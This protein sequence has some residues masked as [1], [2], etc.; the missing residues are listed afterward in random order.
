[1]KKLRVLLLEDSPLDA[2]LTLATLAEAG[3]ECDVTRVDTR[4]TFTAA[5]DADA[6]TADA[7]AA[8]FGAASAAPLDLILADHQLPSFDGITALRIAR[9]R[10]PSVPFIFLSGTLGEELAIEAMKTGATDY[11]VK[12]RMTRLAPAVRRA[13]REAAE[14][15]RLE[16]TSAQLRGS[17]ERCRLV[18][19]TA[20]DFAIVTL[21]AAGVV[22]SWNGGAERILGFAPAE[23]VGR[24]FA[25]F[26]TPEDRAAGMPQE[27]L[28]R[29][30][31]EGRAD[32]DRWHVRKDGTRFFA[33]G[34]VTA[35][36]DGRF[37][38]F[39][40]ILRDTTGRKRE[41]ESLKRSIDRLRLLSETATYLL[42]THDQRQIV[43]DLFDKLSPQLSLEL[44]LAYLVEDVEAA[45]AHDLRLLA[46][47]GVADDALAGIRR[48]AVGQAVCGAV[49][50]DGRRL[51]C[52]DVQ[53]SG[54]PRA[55]LVRALGVRAYAC[56]PLVA[57]GRVIGTL[58]LGTRG[59]TRFTPDELELMQTVADQIAAALERVRLLAREKAARE[60][61]EAASAT[62]VAANRA[63][64]EF[65]ATVS[66]EL[67]TPLT[68][69]LGWARMLRADDLDADTL[70][71]AIETI[72][73]NAKVQAQLI[74]DILDISRIISGKLRLNVGPTRFVRVAQEAV[75]SLRPAADARG[76]TLAVTVD[77]AAVVSGDPDRL[78][79]VVWNLLSNAIKFTPRGGHVALR[80]D[81]DGQR[82]RVSV[83]DTG[84][85]ITP[86][87]LPHVFDR[88]RQADASSTRRH[89][90]LGLGLAIV[91]HLIELHGGTIE[92][93]SDGDGKGARFEVLLPLVEPGP[94]A[95]A[96]RGPRG[97]AGGAADASRAGFDCAPVLAGLRVMV[98]DDEPDTRRLLAAVL[99]RCEAEV[100]VAGSVAEA[101]A[102]WSGP[103]PTCC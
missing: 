100:T 102:H 98:V 16:E 89:G 36:R 4:E 46:S 68:A 42:S 7:A 96:A 49:A 53:A 27:E 94:A 45:G 95:A 19:E 14:R 101:Q 20:T 30:A 17:E 86:A 12:Q 50:A 88:F 91:R 33:S 29:A 3:F 35:L 32:D 67:R 1:M 85:G 5:L 55:A 28:R 43:D 37:S 78:Q 61:A 41:E 9:E 10:R 80:V 34:V 97:T 39:L 31:A 26:F 6:D 25:E 77:P 66:H 2:E 51:V 23:I 75:D 47:R 15:R 76:L 81:R 74:D 72:E 13:L 82:C 87:F 65:L 69:I 64:D 92:A 44:C 54:D 58:S 83:A 22:Q 63:K 79:Q 103:A 73:R 38:G 70:A 62:A 56:H 93:H 8:A 99:Q 57:D 71:E 40:K 90:G 48:V 84:K 52:E 21:D 18:I 59:R 11:V 24:N 60:A